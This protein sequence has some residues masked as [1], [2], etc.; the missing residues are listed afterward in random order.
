M[1]TEVEHA[2]QTWRL[3]WSH[4]AH[5]VVSTLPPHGECEL[6]FAGYGWGVRNTR[7]RRALLIHPTARLRDVGD[8]SLTV[9]GEGTQ[10][11]PRLGSDLP[12]YLDH[13]TDIVETM[14]RSYILE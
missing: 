6:V 4:A 11:I 9:R 3:L 13:V 5:Q 1:M 10:V 12:Q 7:T 2:E 8:L 14:L